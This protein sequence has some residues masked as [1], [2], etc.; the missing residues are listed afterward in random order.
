[1]LMLIGSHQAIGFYLEKSGVYDEDEIKV[2]KEIPMDFDFY[3]EH[4]MKETEHSETWK[5]YYPK[6]FLQ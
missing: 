2:L 5:L 1:M 3:L 6:D 4:K